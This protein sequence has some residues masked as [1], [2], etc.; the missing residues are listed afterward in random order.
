MR[1]HFINYSH[2]GGDVHCSLEYM[3]DLYSLI[4]PSECFLHHF[5]NP[6]F[7]IDVPFIKSSPPLLI[8]DTPFQFNPPRNKEGRSPCDFINFP[9]MR[10]GNEYLYQNA[11]TDDA[12]YIVTWLAYYWF[13]PNPT[14][15]FGHCCFEAYQHAFKTVYDELG[16]LDH[17]KP[18]Q[19]YITSRDYNYIDRT[20]I[21]AFH[22]TTKYKK[23]L[24]SNG[25]VLSGQSSNF[26]FTPILDKL[27]R[28][29]PNVIFI[30]TKKCSLDLPNIRFTSD[31]IGLPTNDLIEIS[32]L[33]LKC[34]MIIG[35]SSGPSSFT[36]VK[37]NYTDKNKTFI[38]ICERRLEGLVYEVPTGE[39][40]KQVWTNN[41][42]LDHIYNL[43]D[44]EISYER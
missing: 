13:G 23:V 7:I 28:K 12:I 41:Y 39:G 30:F 22:E 5:T 16:I 34:N 2:S 6:R 17:Y 18:L 11:S 1:L 37:E 14:E 21:D 10:H 26:D 33:S 25:D 3:K 42:D 38:A 43:I 20:N 15:L 32:Y 4:E 24:V 19:Y 29:H 35:R 8:K 27:A 9:G 31:I 44:Q 36:M 40:C